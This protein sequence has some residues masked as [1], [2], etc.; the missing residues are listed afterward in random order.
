M[1]DL[2]RPWPAGGQGMS[3]TGSW[4]ALLA[5]GKLHR[6]GLPDG[7]TLW[8]A[9]LQGA[10]GAGACME[11]LGMKKLIRSMGPEQL[12]AFLSSSSSRGHTRGEAK[13]HHVL[14]YTQGMEMPE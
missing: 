12:A 14:F 9:R 7:E 8:Q 6:G 2:K 13:T 11:G 10:E 1:V 4:W 5:S 3:S